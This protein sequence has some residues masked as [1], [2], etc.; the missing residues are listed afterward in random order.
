MVRLFFVLAIGGILTIAPAAAKK[1]LQVGDLAPEI[2]G[3]TVNKKPIMRDEQAGTI[4]LMSFWATWCAPCRQEIPVL[5]RMASL[6]QDTDLKVIAVSFQEGRSTTKKVIEKIGNL[7]VTF[8][9]DKRSRL[10]KAFKVKS[11]PNLW[12]IGR[13]GRILFHKTGYGEAALPGL[14]DVVNAA[15]LGDDL[16]DQA[17]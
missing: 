9:Y 3:Y 10:A 8:A 16:S 11:I 4:V 5:A 2:L 6:T 13:D 14:V 17:R 12:I 1:G 7:E 15:I